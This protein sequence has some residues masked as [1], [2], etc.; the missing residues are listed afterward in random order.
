MKSIKEIKAEIESSTAESY[1]DII[2]ALSSD[3]R[4]GVKQLTARLRSDIAKHQKEIQR[5]KEMKKYES[6][7]REQGFSAIAGIDEVGRGPLCGPVVSAAVIFPETSSIPYINDSKKLSPKKREEL[8]EIII[9]E[10]VCFS[11]GIINSR[12]IDEINIFNAVKLSMKQAVTS[13]SSEPDIILIDYLTLDIDIPNRGIQGGDSEIY[14]IAAAS[15]IAKVT[16][17]RI[18]A[19][20][21]E[22]YPEYGLESN[23]GYGSQMHINALKKYGPSPIH[24]KSFIKG[25]LGTE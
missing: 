5:I 7:L 16:R 6:A 20:Y 24:R 10:A 12:T 17:D 19:E 14:C 13:L 9:S 25:L 15:I 4:A 11:A 18:M 21:A 2:A 1:P 22:L 8:Y 3:S 23:K